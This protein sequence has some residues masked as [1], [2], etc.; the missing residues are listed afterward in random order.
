M[1]A[2]EFNN[3]RLNRRKQLYRLKLGLQQ[4]INHPILNCLWIV[5]V[6]FI[7]ALKASIEQLRE[8]VAILIEIPAF[9]SIFEVSLKI[10]V[11]II[12]TISVIAIIQFIGYCFA[13][14][15]ESDLAIVFGDRRDVNNQFPILISKKHNR[16]T[17]VTKREFYTSIPMSRWQ[18]KRDAICDR[19]NIHIIGDIMYGGKSH[20]KGNLI[21]LESA[22]GRKPIER[23]DLYDD[24]F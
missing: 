7:Y 17:G 4:M 22:K 14:R 18:E 6:I 24:E 10:A 21:Y 12:P 13:I 1:K 9:K 15:D 19:L 3:N 5:F 8:T 11:I 23:G 20:N 16:K 2:N